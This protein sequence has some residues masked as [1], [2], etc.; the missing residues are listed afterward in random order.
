VEYLIRY[1]SNYSLTI[2]KTGNYAILDVQ[3]FFLPSSVL[4]R[5]LAGKWELI[6]PSILIL[7]VICCILTVGFSNLIASLERGTLFL[8]SSA[9]VFRYTSIV[10][11]FWYLL[12]QSKQATALISSRVFYIRS[13]CDQLDLWL[14]VYSIWQ[15]YFTEVNSQNTQLYWVGK[16]SIEI[17]PQS[18]TNREDLFYTR[19]EA[20]HHKVLVTSSLRQRVAFN[21]RNV[22]HCFNNF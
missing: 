4:L 10:T 14:T 21:V 18:G 17:K 2:K 3:I 12:P 1:I 6:F 20:R 8:H 5:L 7:K 9:H 22:K 16:L 15:N 19:L 11:S 13:F